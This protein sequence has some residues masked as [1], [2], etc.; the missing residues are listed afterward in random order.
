MEFLLGE[1]GPY[2]NE[3]V[4]RFSPTAP[5]LGS[6]SSC[7]VSISSS[8]LAIVSFRDATYQH[9]DG[10]ELHFL[11]STSTKKITSCHTREKS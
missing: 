11:W 4:L 9:S 5:F 1:V 10:T 7:S 3:F 8:F 6:L 2:L